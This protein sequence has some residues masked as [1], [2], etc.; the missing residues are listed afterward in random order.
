MPLHTSGEALHSDHNR[1][2]FISSATNMQHTCEA[3]QKNFPLE[4]TVTSLKMNKLEHPLMCVSGSANVGHVKDQR[5]TIPK[6]HKPQNLRISVSLP[7]SS[8]FSV[9]CFRGSIQYVKF[10]KNKTRKLTTCLFIFFL[11]QTTLVLLDRQLYYKCRISI[12]WHQATF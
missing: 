9:S 4:K 2:I 12:F 6:R 11:I 3:I 10:N 5:G 1:Q 8:F 7:L